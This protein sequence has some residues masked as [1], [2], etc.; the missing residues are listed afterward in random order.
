MQIHFLEESKMKLRISILLVAASLCSTAFAQQ[1]GWNNVTPGNMQWSN[2]PSRGISFTPIGP[3]TYGSDGSSSYQS[4]NTTINSN[5]TSS[6]NTGE[7]VIGSDG[8]R[9][10]MIGDT[11]YGQRPDGTRFSC[12]QQDGQTFCY[13]R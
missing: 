4:G 13:P 5:G 8:T 6:Y 1:I 2:V 3:S 11:L 7:T 10:R 12:R 9:M